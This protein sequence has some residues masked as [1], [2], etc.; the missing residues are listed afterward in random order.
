MV[1]KK[2]DG[3]QEPGCYRQFSY[4]WSM[5]LLIFAIVCIFYG[6]GKGWNNPPWSQ[7][8]SH[9]V[10][11]AILFLAMMY[12]IALLEGCQISIVGLQDV[13]MEPYKLSHPRAYHVAQLLFKGPGVERFLVGRQFLLLFNGF[14]CSKVGGSNTAGPTDRFHMGDWEWGDEGTQFFWLNSVFLMIVIIVPGQLV[15]QLLANDKMME[16]LDLPAVQAPYTVAYPCLFVESLGLTHSAYL[17]KDVLTSLSGIDRSEEDP[18]KKMKKDFF[19]YARVFLS[20]SAVVFTGIFLFKGWF[21]LQSGATDGAGWRKMPGWLAIIVSCF[22]LFVMAC[23]EGLQVSGLA[24]EKKD[25]SVLKEKKPLAHATLELMFRGNNMAAFLIGRQ[26]LVAMMM[27]LLGKVT[28][29][30]GG[31]GELV[32]GKKMYGNA[33]DGSGATIYMEDGITAEREFIGTAPGDDWG[34]GST[35]NEWCLQTGFF[36]AVF[37]VNVAQLATQVTASIFPVGFIN[38]RF[39]NVLLRVMLLVEA[40]GVLNAVYPIAWYLDHTFKL[41]RDPFDEEDVLPTTI[42]SSQ[43]AAINDSANY[44]DV[45]VQGGGAPV[46]P[47]KISAV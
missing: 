28:S 10:A 41:R 42:V 29:Y 13:N 36:G 46:S 47:Q 17:L 3:A 34:M 1:F 21:V 37:V 39:L 23:A 15:S 11:E 9:P 19:Y 24:M 43:P 8:E 45:E 7:K 32:G 35:F 2:K 20:C 26:C 22:F 30:A 5:V 16:F 44:L 25:I 14:L 40:S 4:L 6:I 38:N 31:G 33:T 18:A 12:W 27:V